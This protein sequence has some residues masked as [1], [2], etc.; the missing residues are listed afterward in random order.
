MSL[1]LIFVLPA[2][3]FLCTPAFG[4]VTPNET[5]VALERETETLSPVREHGLTQLETRCL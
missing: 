5:E 2:A 4:I 1:D 3:A